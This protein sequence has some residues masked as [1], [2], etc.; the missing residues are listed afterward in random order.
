MAVP[1]LSQGIIASSGGSVVLKGDARPVM[2]RALQPSVAGKAADHEALLAALPRHRSNPCQGA[3]GVVVSSVQ[4]LC[5]LGEQCGEID[6]ADSWPGAKDRHVALL[7]VLPRGMLFFD[8]DA[9]TVQVLLRLLDLLIDQMQTCRKT[10]DMSAGG[11]RC[12]R[13][14]GNVRYFV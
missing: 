10:A 14:H 2:N 6:P 5:G 8:L 13:R 1:A 9:Q 7:G 3:Q 11:L 12:A 4:G